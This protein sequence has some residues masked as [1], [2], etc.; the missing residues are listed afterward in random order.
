M[1]QYWN[2][3]NRR[4]FMKLGIAGA[5]GM[6]LSGCSG[7]RLGK[8]KPIPV[9]LQLYS[10]RHECAKD[11]GRNLTQ[12]I[13]AVADMGY[14]GVEFAGYYNWNPT[15][16]RT[17]LDDHGL[18]A[19]STHTSLKLLQGDEFGKTVDLHHTIGADHIIVP[20]LPKQYTSSIEGWKEVCGLFNDITAKLKP[21]NLKTGYHNHS[22][23]FKPLGDTTGWDVFMS[24]TVDDVIMQ[25]DVGNCMG[26]NGD[27][28]ASIKKYPG[29]ADA[30]HI[31]EHGG[32]R[33]TVVGEGDAP[34][35]EIIEL[36]RTVA[37]TEWFIIEHER[38]REGSLE[39]VDRCLQNFRGL[40]TE[41][42]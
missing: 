17:L 6:A 3:Q 29:R 16:L 8:P 41:P 9:A 7:L 37:G 23:E 40:M 11:E 42:V 28:V 10:V 12:V 33:K 34:L 27:P 38:V 14:D 21:H 19:I 26:G 15:D 1:S 5:A 36:A 32:D 31:K 2:V 30:I 13:K 24:N 20:S 39:A 18:R 35:K 4:E 25:L 22:V